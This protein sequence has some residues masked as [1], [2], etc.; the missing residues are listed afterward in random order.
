[1]SLI[2]RE[3]THEVFGKGIIIEYDDSFIEIDFPSELSGTKK[4]VFPDAFGPFL[5]PVGQETADLVDK[6]K[7]EKR[8]KEREARDRRLKKLQKRLK[9]EKRARKAKARRAHPRSQSVFWCKPEEL[10]DIFTNWR[11]F[12]G[13]I[14][15]GQRKG[16][17]RRLARLKQNSACLITVREP[18]EQ[19]AERRIVG[20]F[21][22]NQFFDAAKCKD[23]YIRAHSRYRLRLSEEV[24]KKMLFWNYYVDSRNPDRISWGSGRQRYFDNEWMAKI[25]EDIILLVEDSQEQGRV[26][27]FL[28]YFCK[29]NNLTKEEIPESSGALVRV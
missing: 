13:V 23:G 8:R 28:E 26:Q 22:V 3:V 11:L 27:D 29:V 19:E 16:Q 17:P 15:S 5:T 4:F 2:N 9:R 1:M 20:V 12:T 14:K 6:I 25:L 21:M 10:K 24:S 7:Q 18:G